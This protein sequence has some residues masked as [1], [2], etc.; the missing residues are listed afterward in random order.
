MLIFLDI[1]T[2]L[3][4]RQLISSNK[5]LY[6]R[7]LTV[8]NGSLCGGRIVMIIMREIIMWLKDAL[9]GYYSDD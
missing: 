1:L 3:L 8:S 2:S 9:I 4:Q 5:S 6:G 7:L